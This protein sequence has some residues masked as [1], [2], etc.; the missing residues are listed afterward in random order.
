MSRLINKTHLKTITSEHKSLLM[1]IVRNG[2]KRHL[3]N[4][5]FLISRSGRDFFTYRKILHVELSDAIEVLQK[6]YEKWNT[7]EVRYNKAK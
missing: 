7:D 2:A 6:L 5:P 3:I 1:K 4:V